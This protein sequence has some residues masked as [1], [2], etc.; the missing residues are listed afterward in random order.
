MTLPEKATVLSIV[1]VA[2]ALAFQVWPRSRASNNCYW[3]GLLSQSVC[4][5]TNREHSARKETSNHCLRRS[6][7]ICSAL[8]QLSTYRNRQMIA[9]D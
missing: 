5:S 1:A 9:L 7:A 3:C 8:A 6:R 4:E 2:V